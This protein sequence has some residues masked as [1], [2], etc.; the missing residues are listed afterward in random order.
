M[1]GVELERFRLRLCGG[2]EV[3]G[4][5]CRE[6]EECGGGGDTEGTEMG[7]G[8]CWGVGRWLSFG[9]PLGRGMG[10]DGCEGR[11]WVAGAEV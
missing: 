3:A 2:G 8:R 9:E 1:D 5:R 7:M 6:G 4:D 10:R 11:A